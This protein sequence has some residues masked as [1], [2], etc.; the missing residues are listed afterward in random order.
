[1]K[2]IILL[3]F[4]AL[5]SV[6]LQAENRADSLT[7]A[8]P[9]LRQYLSSIEKGMQGDALWRS[10]SSIELS[11]ATINATTTT[12]YFPVQ[13]VDSSNN[14]MQWFN[15]TVT[16]FSV[17][18]SISTSVGQAVLPASSKAFY[19]GSAGLSVTITGT[20]AIGDYITVTIPA[21]S[22]GCLDAVTA[23]QILTFTE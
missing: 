13:L 16:P 8:S 6:F 14:L 22:D 18:Q 11:T 17:A 15:D 2:N 19:A 12:L 1:M 9:E 7:S 5:F 20:W 4:V 10:Y 21:L 3:V 23:T